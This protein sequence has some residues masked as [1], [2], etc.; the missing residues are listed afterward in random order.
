MNTLGMETACATLYNPQTN[1]QVERFNK[2]IVCLL[3]QYV[4]DHVVTCE[5]YASLLVTAYNSRVH[6]STGEAPFSFV[7][8]RRLKPATIKRITQTEGETP[9]QAPS[10][11]EAALLQNLY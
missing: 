1:G 7:R 11:A 5:R 4:Q 3:R 6:S 2:P 8:Q 9:T 10:Q